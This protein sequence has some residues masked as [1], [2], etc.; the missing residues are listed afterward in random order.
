DFKLSLTMK[1]NTKK[2]LRVDA[3]SKRVDSK[4]AHP[5]HKLLLK[6]I[7]EDVDKFHKI[8]LSE[9]SLISLN[10][11]D[12][13]FL[14]EELLK[15]FE[16]LPDLS[17]G[18]INC[19]SNLQCELKKLLKNISFIYGPPGTGKTTYVAEKLICDVLDRTYLF[20]KELTDSH[21]FMTEAVYE[22]YKKHADQLKILVVAPTNKAADVVAQKIIKTCEN[23]VNT[24]YSN[25]MVRFETTD[26][27]EIEKKASASILERS[28]NDKFRKMKGTVLITTIHR[29]P[30]DGFKSR[31][32]E[33]LF[34]NIEWDMVIFDEA[35][36]I[37]VAAIVH[38]LYRV[39]LTNPDCQFVVAGDPFQIPP[40]QLVDLW[41]DENFYKM[42]GLKSFS[43]D[44]Q[45]DEMWDMIGIR[46]S[47]HNLETQFRSI[48]TIGELFSKFSYDSLLSHSRGNARKPIPD[49]G[50][51]VDDF[52]IINYPIN[53]NS[54][55][56]K[57]SRL[58]K[59]PYH[60][61]SVLFTVLLIEHMLAKFATITEE[62]TIG[63]ICP[64]R[65]QADL[66][67]KI[68]T[69]K[70]PV[71]DKV[72][73]S[74]ATVHG[75]QGDEC[76]I[77]ICLLNSPSGINQ[78]NAKRVFV[79]Q[80]YILNVAISRARDYLFLLIPNSDTRGYQN[81]TGIKKI[82]SIMESIKKP[83]VHTSSE[84]EKILKDNQD[85]VSEKTFITSHQL[86]N[87]YSTVP[88]NDYEFRISED[89][90]DVQILD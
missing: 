37:A 54:L 29:F 10:I 63:I 36:M 8:N 57:S 25:Y 56:Y 21:G 6:F 44:K 75:F 66:V 3:V 11:K 23:N 86:V 14:L 73:I 67:G 27:D 60:P 52:N 61:Y 48:N 17:V 55:L 43:K 33:N 20:K 5:K 4:G 7:P 90:V 83:V 12:P 9:V 18:A 1:D 81:L 74:T 24:N 30:Y 85:F 16:E 35:S 28:D 45:E 31:N 82:L 40:I 87:V 89:A 46:Y 53:S 69:T 72:K 2:E 80:Q 78:N 50:F 70:L 64:Y 71:H 76:D 68:I 59:S 77:M 62:I 13:V 39:R 47:V 49:L 88:E 65:V 38:V 58:K 79:N 22:S 32:D 41:S 42:C 15:K 19:E 51:E 34:R 84:M 26:S